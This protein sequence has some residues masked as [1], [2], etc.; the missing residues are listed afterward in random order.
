MEK[1]QSKDGTLIAFERSGEG[2]PLVVVPGVLTSSRQWPIL[3]T[4]GNHFTVYAVD[5][6]GHG[7]SGDADQYAIEREFEDIAAVVDA[8]GSEVNVLGHSFGGHCVLGASLLTSNIRG[9][10]VYETD[11]PEG[12]YAESMPAGLVDKFESLVEAGDRAGAVITFFR[13]ALQ[14]TPQ[15]IE[16]AE[17]WPTFPAMVAGADTFPREIRAVDAYQFETQQF[18]QMNV[19]TLLL[20]GGDSPDFAKTSMERWHEVLPNSRLVI[21]PGQQHIAH[22]TA[23]DLFIHE[24]QTFLSALD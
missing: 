3:P 23:P 22:Y 21:L 24:V 8:I 4:L 9:L 16:G 7:D 5:R 15:E 13:E 2:P 20:L 6:R 1:V 14:M 18:R 12:M 19:P 17:K 10:V 11:A